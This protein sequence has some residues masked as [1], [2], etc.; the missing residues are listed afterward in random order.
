MNILRI[1]FLLLIF[2]GQVSGQIY[3][4]YLSATSAN[5][6]LPK[7][8]WGS[9]GTMGTVTFTVGN[10]GPQDMLHWDS[11]GMGD[12][13]KLIIQISP[14]TDYTI[15]GS[16]T[17]DGA[18]PTGTIAS[19]FSW[20]YLFFEG[21]ATLRGT[22]IATI[23]AGESGT[24]TFPITHVAVS[25]QANISPCD[26]VPNCYGTQVDGSF[27]GLNGLVVNIL[28]P[29]QPANNNEPLAN[30]NLGGYEY[31]LTSLPLR[32]L[33]FQAR[34]LSDR[35]VELIWTTLSEQ[36]HREFE[37][38]R[39]DALTK[40]WGMIG[41]K[42][43]VGF[44]TK[45]TEY[46]Y[47]DQVNELNV[48][49]V[50]YRLK[51]VKVNGAFEYS[52]VRMVSLNRPDGITINT[53]PNPFTKSFYLNLNVNRDGPVAVQILDVLG[54]QVFKENNIVPK[55]ITSKLIQLDQVPQGTYSVH[56]S[57]DGSEQ[58]LKMLKIN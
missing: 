15:I 56:V 20:N 23:A 11:C 3:D 51:S 16:N 57:F 5:F 55:G 1:L 49:K 58:I 48:S 27:R 41:K 47:I 21:N 9:T 17:D 43:A 22:Q 54:R 10:H 38:E 36:N 25:S 53:F 45:K 7:S 28:P 12:G 8:P 40:A 39:F 42:V 6:V 31:S 34:L 18:L 46:G 4:P 14:N 24:I 32:S 13:C 35:K 19:K 26:G 2:S 33:H 30:N 50:Y 37:V 44:S 29:S 52:D